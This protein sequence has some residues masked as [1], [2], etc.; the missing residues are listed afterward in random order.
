VYRHFGQFRNTPRITEGEPRKD[1]KLSPYR[2]YTPKEP[3]RRDRS[4][5]SIKGGHANWN[6]LFALCDWQFFIVI[7]YYY[8]GSHFMPPRNLPIK[9][10]PTTNKPLWVAGEGIGVATSLA[11]CV[12][13]VLRMSKKIL[14]GP[15]FAFETLV[16]WYIAGTREVVLLS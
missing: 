3:V 10:A 2:G 11:A 8:Y 13:A 7:R 5:T 1:H 15:N 14:R 4:A 6:D 12:A 16:P 9:S